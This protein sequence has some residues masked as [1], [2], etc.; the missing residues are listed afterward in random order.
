[1]PK[2]DDTLLPVEEVRPPPP[3]HQSEKRPI[4]RMALLKGAFFGFAGFLLFI[5]IQRFG[6]T[7]FVYGISGALAGIVSPIIWDT[8]KK[9]KEE[10]KAFQSEVDARFDRLEQK[11]STFMS[12]NELD[13]LRADIGIARADCE[14]SLQIAKFSSDTAKTNQDRI[15]DIISSGVIFQLTQDVTIMRLQY[16]V[17]KKIIQKRK[18]T[19]DDLD[20]IIYEQ[21]TK[22]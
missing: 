7:T 11:A 4:S 12:H 18:V 1:M 8:F 19:L 20:L 15:N 14:R 9:Q 5:E 10:E 13:P 3:T 16:S 17:M 2:D 6:G 22:L 21:Q